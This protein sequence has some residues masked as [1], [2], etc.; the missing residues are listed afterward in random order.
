ME[1]SQSA[2]FT[3]EVAV[4]GSRKDGEH[5]TCDDLFALVSG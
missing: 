1:R 4:L 3:D 5:D 2:A